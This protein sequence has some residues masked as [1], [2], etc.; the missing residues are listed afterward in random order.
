VLGSG[1]TE[2]LVASYASINSPWR[3]MVLFVPS[4]LKCIYT[5]YYNKNTGKIWRY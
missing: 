4:K 5:L 3:T 1:A 2:G